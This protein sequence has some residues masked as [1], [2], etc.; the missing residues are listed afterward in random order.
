MLVGAR[1]LEARA[2]R[3]RGIAVA[4]GLRGAAA[5]RGPVF[6]RSKVRR[7]RGH[8]SVSSAARRTRERG[9]SPA[10]RQDNPFA[11]LRRNLLHEARDDAV[12][13]LAVEHA[14]SRVGEVQPLP[15]ARDR[16]VHEAPLL[17][18]AAVLEHAVLVREETLLEPGDEHAGELEAL[19]RVHGHQL[20]RVLAG[21]GLALAGLEARMREER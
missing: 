15:R 19:G 14:A 13:R 6:S 4:V 18:D 7:P 8:T 10:L 3:R 20:Q 12:A 17:L 16:D 2:L 21:G 9:M 11:E 5:A 1:A